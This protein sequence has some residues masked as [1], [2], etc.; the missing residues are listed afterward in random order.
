MRLFKDFLCCLRLK[1]AGGSTA[2]PKDALQDEFRPA[3]YLTSS[4]QK[5]LQTLWTEDVTFTK[6][7]DACSK[8]QSICL[9][10]KPDS[11]LIKA[12]LAGMSTADQTEARKVLKD[13]M[14]LLQFKQAVIE[15]ELTIRARLELSNKLKELDIKIC[16]DVMHYAATAPHGLVDQT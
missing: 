6:Y 1:Q 3:D 12:M 14:S 8:L 5:L 15:V 13:K 2:S 11:K 4:K 10:G 16:G 7:F 9:K